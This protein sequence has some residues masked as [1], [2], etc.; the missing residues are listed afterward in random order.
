MFGKAKVVALES[1]VAFLRRQVIALSERND[2]LIEAL[3][4]K[5]DVPLVLPSVYAPPEA[6]QVP[7]TAPTVT[8]PGPTTDRG[9]NDWWHAVGASPKISTPV[10]ESSVPAPD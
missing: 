9:L 1:E 6:I 4:R 2:R 8:I 10:K 3:A 7:D 5:S